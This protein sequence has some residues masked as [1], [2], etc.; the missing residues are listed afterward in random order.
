MTSDAT[1]PGP[2]QPT[3]ANPIAFV[4][5]AFLLGT[6]CGAVLMWAYQAGNR[7]ALGQ[8]P[9]V[10]APPASAK[11]S[12]PAASAP[13]SG[14]KEDRVGEEFPK[15]VALEATD[16]RT[17]MLYE[18]HGQRAFAVFVAKGKGS[19]GMLDADV[20]SAAKLVKEYER[21]KNVT[22]GGEIFIIWPGGKED[23]CAFEAAVRAAA[24]VE[25][26]VFDNPTNPPI[27][28]DRHFRALDALEL[29]GDLA[30]RALIAVDADF[31]IMNWILLKDDANVVDLGAVEAKI[32]QVN[33]AVGAKPMPA[34]KIPMFE[35]DLPPGFDYH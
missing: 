2:E 16:S 27:L 17:Y 6:I 35:N 28:W 22:S 7:P 11:A 15:S 19:A 29:K 5:V 21:F 31:K 25:G 30:H 3:P 34:K 8:P 10:P 24:G 4:L 13:A 9:P 1:E 20:Q 32:K 33:E 18:Y 12:K 23:V 26:D 14:P